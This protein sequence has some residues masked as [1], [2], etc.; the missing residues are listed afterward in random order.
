MQN[1]NQKS[2]NYRN[3]KIQKIHTKNTFK[4]SNNNNYNKNIKLHKSAKNYKFQPEVSATQTYE[5]H[6]TS[7]MF[8]RQITGTQSVQNKNKKTLENHTKNRVKPNNNSAYRE[9]IKLQKQTKIYK[10]QQ[11]YLQYKIVM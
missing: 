1:I 10:N 6:C 2:T 9:N 5:T 8:Y 4:P 11:K 7:L 3:T